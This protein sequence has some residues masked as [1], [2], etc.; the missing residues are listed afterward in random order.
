MARYSALKAELQ[1]SASKVS[2]L[3]PPKFEWDLKNLIAR[4]NQAALPC[5]N[6][7][8]SYVKTAKAAQDSLSGGSMSSLSGLAS[9]LSAGPLVV[10]KMA[11]ESSLNACGNLN[12]PSGKEADPAVEALWKLTRN[13]EN[14]LKTIAES[15]ALCLTK[16]Y[17]KSQP[18]AIAKPSTPTAPQAPPPCSYTYSGWSPCRPDGIQSRSVVSSTPPG[19]QGTPD[20]TQTCTYKPPAPPPPPPKIITGEAFACNAHTIREGESTT[21][22]W[23]LVYSDDT[24]EELTGKAR[25][26]PGTTIRGKA[27]DVIT[28]TAIY[29]GMKR[30]ATVKV[31]GRDGKGYDPRK[32]SG[33]SGKE[34]PVDSAKLKKLTEEFGSGKAQGTRSALPQQPTETAIPTDYTKPTVK[35]GETSPKEPG[36]GQQTGTTVQPTSPKPPPAKTVKSCVV[37]EADREKLRKA[38]QSKYRDGP[39]NNGPWSVAACKPLY[40]GCI[41][42]VSAVSKSI[43]WKLKSACTKQELDKCWE[44][45]NCLDKAVMAKDKDAAAKCS[46]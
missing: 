2:I 35:S 15:K 23:V 26:D 43:N 31:V 25:W 20:L 33:L 8:Q 21:C 19:C 40:S 10:Q 3:I 30:M 16:L 44:M 29:M 14:W 27:G 22:G 39:E 18:P 17:P 6:Q 13:M 12:P 9:M 5:P 7:I 32:D 11:I 36:R 28:V 42:W 34:R 38:I 41:T 45:F 37:T 46:K 4:I 1:Q 24:L